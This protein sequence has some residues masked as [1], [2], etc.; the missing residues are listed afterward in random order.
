MGENGFSIVFTFLFLCYS[1]NNKSIIEWI[2]EYVWRDNYRYEE[3]MGG[4]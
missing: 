1:G 2:G 3:K 4:S